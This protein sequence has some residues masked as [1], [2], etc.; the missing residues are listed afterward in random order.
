MMRSSIFEATAEDVR[1]LM[2]FRLSGEVT[3]TRGL[4]LIAEGLRVPKG[5][6]CKIYC[7]GTGQ[8][9]EGEVVE[10]RQDRAFLMLYSDMY[11]IAQG[12][13]VECL[14]TRQKVGVS[15]ELLGR[16]IDGRGNPVDGGEEIF[17][18][19][20]YPIY[21]QAPHPLTRRRILDPIA[22]G[23]RAIDGAF[24]VGKG[25]RMGIF[26]GT[27][28]GK[29][30][31]LGM[32]AR[33]TSADVNVVALIGERGREV[34]EFIEKDLGPE[35][36]KRTVMVVSTSDTPALLRVRA[37]FVA[38]AIAEYFR[39]RGK[40]VMLLM[41]SVTRMAFAQREIG[42][43]TGDIPASKGFGAT[44]FA[45][46]PRLMERAGQSDVGSIT[47]FF[48]VLVEG[49]DIT[50]PISD[51]V[52]GILDGHVV[53]S[54]DLA[55]RGHYPAIDVPASISRV[56]P[57]V[58]TPEHLAASRKL[59]EVV[60]RY[61]ASEDMI[62]IGAYAAGSNAEIDEAIR[63]MPEVN[64]FLRQNIAERAI[65]EETVDRLLGI[66]GDRARE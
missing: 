62:N 20:Y 51:T 40:D 19:D 66:V 27:G 21:S 16:V 35:G 22:T 34:R 36:M 28:V 4:A 23:I 61:R 5:S 49:D 37:P 11:G 43:S 33:N 56:M 2:P 52:R 54:R 38:A 45:Q 59:I 25:Q 29:S 13:E 60:A 24:T 14:S 18:E 55:T 10:F 30:V 39:D 12:D 47:A 46:F 65:Y 44:V 7:R 41:D 64:G 50:E 17:F 9:L 57:D 31:L 8:T 1:S 6:L 15:D 32:I 63:L 3:E 48:S 58:V 42:I 26:S 53:L